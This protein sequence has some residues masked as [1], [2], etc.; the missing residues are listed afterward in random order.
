MFYFVL[1]LKLF[2]LEFIKRGPIIKITINFFIIIIISCIS[3]AKLKVEI[4]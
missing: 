1:E 3:F 4:L 2:V